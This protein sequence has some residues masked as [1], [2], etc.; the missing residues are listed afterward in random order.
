MLS[1][2]DLAFAAINIGGNALLGNVTLYNLKDVPLPP[3]GGVAVVAFREKPM[4]LNSLFETEADKAAQCKFTGLMVPFD[5]T[6]TEIRRVGDSEIEDAPEPGK[7]SAYAIVLNQKVCPGVAPEPVML[8][9]QRP[10]FRTLFNSDVML[11]SHNYVFQPAQV[12]TEQNKPR[13]IEQVEERIRLAA[14]SDPN[15]R[16]FV[17]EL[18][19]ATAR[20][21]E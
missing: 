6:W 15:A 11:H 5:R 9:A 1:L 18:E 4:G 16:V 14:D 21:T 19:L 12:L 8:F 3:L 13:W 17:H 20:P 2:L 10:G 7:I